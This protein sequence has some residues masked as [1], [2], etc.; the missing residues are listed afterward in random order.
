[1]RNPGR[2]S[3]WLVCFCLWVS[4]G[5]IAQQPD[6][7]S[8]F[9]RGLKAYQSGNYTQAQSAFLDMIRLYPEGKLI[10]AAK[11]MLAKTYY[12]QGDYAG[13][14]IIAQNF[15]KKHPTSSYVDD[16]HYLLGNT[17]FR[18]KKYRAAVEEWLWVIRESSDPRL[19]RKA[20]R[21]VYQTMEHF[22]TAEDLETFRPRDRQEYLDGL[23]T[24][25]QAK[26]LIRAGREREAQKLLRTFLNQQPNHFYSDE[27]RRLLKGKALPA[28]PRRV[29]L[30]LKN[31][32][33][34]YK[35]ISEALGLGMRYALQEYRARQGN[36]DLSLLDAE[37]GNSVLS[38]LKTTYQHLK[39]E[40]PLGVI[41]PV[42]QDQSAALA[43]VS[44]YE[45]VPTIVP[46]SSQIG[47]TELS[48]YTFQINPDV[49]TKGDFL[50]Q[51]A[52]QTLGLK[53]LAVMAPA[54]EYGQGFVQ[55][56]V[57]AAQAGGSEVV[58]IQWYYPTSTDFSRQ[59]RQI[60]R[61]AFFVSF[62]DSILQEDSTLTQEELRLRFS[63]YL[64][65][66][67][68]P[69]SPGT[70]VDSTQVPA[71]GIDGLLIVTSP[72]LIEYLAPQFAFHNIQTTLLGNEGWNDPDLLRKYKDYLGRLYFITTGFIDPESWN[73][74]EFSSRFRTAMKVTPGAYHM[75]GYDLMKWIL[76]NYRTGDT[77]EALRNRLEK[78]AL[79]RGILENI[80]FSGKP[81][82]NNRL[83]V[84]KFELGQLLEVE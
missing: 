17:Y 83:T 70:S 15:F 20:G 46:L 25:L 45:E 35:D 58:T 55:S 22:F 13:V 56:F 32:D 67:F 54:N 71:T 10:T 74:R 62:R 39:D 8:L 84:V 4:T 72:D 75:L 44:R 18:Q 37:V 48:P 64:E 23:M 42:D 50:G 7:S 31:T 47:L 21:Y 69:A 26:K 49:Q 73:F 38:A 51:Y 12:K 19:R 1:M 60:R 27:A 6:E 24:V 14:L 79:Y 2:Y 66:K 57:E 11:L 34:D 5:L 61:Q 9:D 76:S 59:F 41:T 82:V 33:E 81:R 77:P 80:Q 68:K 29:L 36:V 65:Q 78:T 53:R 28:G 3:L 43:A 40:H 63:D 30:Y 16:M 52:S